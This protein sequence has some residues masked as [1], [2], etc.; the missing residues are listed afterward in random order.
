MALPA[1]GAVVA[2]P[3]AEAG[4]YALKL[5]DAA[6]LVLA[7]VDFSVAGARNLAGNLERDAE[8]DLTLNGSSFAPGADIELQ[9]VAPY[10]GTGLI[11]IERDRVYSHRW[12][13]ADTTTSVQRIRLPDDLEGNAYV[14]VAF[15]RELGSPEVFVSPLSYAV[16]PITIDRAARELA[17]RLDAPDRV[18][19]GDTLRV[20]YATRRPGRLLLYAVDEGI[21][22]VANYQAPQPLQTFLRKQALQVS[23]YQ[24]VDLIL[25]EFERL[26]QRAAPGGG[27]AARLAEGN[28]NPFRRRDEPPVVFWSGV[29]QADTTARTLEWPVPDYFNGALRVMAVAVNDT[30]AGHAS[31]RTVR[32]AARS[33]SAPTW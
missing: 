25:P 7:Q 31:A 9:I 23:T 5:V 27:S 33:S 1:E 17:I 10:T 20:E 29:L 21:L 11:T 32:F 6:G 14:S 18:Q 3:T 22:Q 15:V 26:R 13:Q 2:L 28:L 19:P 30:Q 24:M 8:L 4:D 16:A 12:F